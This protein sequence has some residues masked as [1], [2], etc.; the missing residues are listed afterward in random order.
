VAFQRHGPK[1]LKS[2]CA[3]FFKKRPLPFYFKIALRL[4]NIIPHNSH[5]A[6][7]FAPDIA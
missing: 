5:L 4:R 7:I 3:A 1:N 2:F 6:C